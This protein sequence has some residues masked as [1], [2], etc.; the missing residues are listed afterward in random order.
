MQALFFLEFLEF[1]S[2]FIETKEDGQT[3]VSN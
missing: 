2:F 1:E 3:D